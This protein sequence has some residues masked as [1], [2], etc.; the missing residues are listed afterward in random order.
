MTTPDVEVE[1]AT[2]AELQVAMQA[3]RTSAERLVERYLVRIAALDRAGPALRAVQETNPDAPAVARALDEERRARGP[4]GPLHGIPVLLK[5]NIATVDRTETTAGALALV[6]ARPRRDATVA[7]RLREAGAVLLG[8]ASM[9][10]WAY[11]KASPSSSGWSARNGQTRNPYALDRSPCGS[12]SGS[13][14][15]VA[16]SLAAVAVGTETDGSIVCPAGVNGVVGIKPTVGLTSR[17]G[18]IP[19]SATQDTVGPF[20]RTVADAAALLGALAGVD[21]RDAA[22]QASAGRSHPDYTRFLA[23]DLRGVRLGVPRAG[24]FGYS[25]RA[26]AVVE[27][28][29]D[30]LRAQGAVVLDPVAIPYFDRAALT[31]VE[32]I[33]LSYEFKAG[34]N[35][36]LAELEPGARVRTLS[37]VIEFNRRDPA[38][39]L[40]YFGQE[41][42][43]RAESRGGL[44]APEYVEALA[45]CR[46]LGRDALDA[47]L[48]AH[49]LD[50]LVAPTTTPAWLIDLVNGDPVR[51]SS[52]KSAALAGYPL[53]SVPAGFVAGLPV[54][55][56]F[57]GRAF[58][59]PALIRLAY[60]FEQAA[61]ARRPPG[62]AVS[63]S[64]H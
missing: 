45:A 56:T 16:A 54:G 9:S 39:N 26:D 58:S 47:V 27:E 17:A 33:V 38:T 8:K 11:F 3:G 61:R 19:I 60:A 36:Y 25:P 63:V 64:T 34:V 28:A 44:E 22:T 5:D 31:E 62:Y 50:A 6:G 30:V 55:V 48:D 4:R 49:G 46:R 40:P 35:A 12:S 37:D 10:E 42:L 52:A 14:V 24:Y 18:V 43:E 20:G 32:R 21:P 7:R 29:L 1:E 53:V 2:V 51:G 23:T 57:M 13:A 59:E 41:L 15:A